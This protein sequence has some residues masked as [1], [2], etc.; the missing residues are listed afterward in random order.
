MRRFRPGKRLIL[1]AGG[2]VA[3]ASAALFMSGVTPVSIPGTAD[4]A[5]LMKE[6]SPGAREKGALSKKA[7]I[8][9]P[10]LA[11]KK[12]L[13]VAAAAPPVAPTPAMVAPAP[14][15]TLPA[16]AAAPAALVPAASG[17][18]VPL[19]L[20]LLLPGGDDDTTIITPPGGPVT[21]PVEEPPPPPPIPEPS[22]WLMMISGFGL[23]GFALRR[24]RKAAALNS[25]GVGSGDSS[26]ARP[27]RQ[28]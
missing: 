13:P 8:A 22:T 18:F 9:A 26:P 20:P 27:V 15:G 12:A 25:T 7:R 16:A 14:V 3:I 10:A 4:L 21:P 23:L 11:A 28:N 5:A 19:M 6:R 1:A 2:A 24:R 17:G